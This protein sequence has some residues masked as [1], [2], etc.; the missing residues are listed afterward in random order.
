MPGMGVHIAGISI[1][2]PYNKFGT[3]TY[4]I[5]IEGNFLF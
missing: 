3:N 2:S 1:K 5:V 4:I